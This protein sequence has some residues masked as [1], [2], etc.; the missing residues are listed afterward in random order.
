[1]SDNTIHLAIGVADAAPAG[2]EELKNQ[3]HQRGVNLLEKGERLFLYPIDDNLSDAF[4]E[5]GIDLNPEKVRL[6]LNWINPADQTVEDSDLTKQIKQVETFN[7]TFQLFDLPTVISYL[8]NNNEAVEDEETR[9]TGSS[10]RDITGSSNNEESQESEPDT[11]PESGEDDVIDQ[12]PDEFADDPPEPS[13]DKPDDAPEYSEEEPVEPPEQTESESEPEQGYDKSELSQMFD[14]NTPEDE[15]S[16]YV[17]D[18]DPWLQAAVKLF[19]SQTIGDDLPSFDSKTQDL[20]S[21]DIVDAN[22]HVDTARQKAIAS[23]YYGLKDSNDKEYAEAEKNEIAKAEKTH[24]QNIDKLKQNCETKIKKVE[25]EEKDK[26]NQRKHEAG[27]AAL[28]DFYSKYDSEHLDEVN[29]IITHR[30]Q[31]IKQELQ[32]NIGEENQSFDEYKDKVRQAVFNHVKEKY[33]V[34]SAVAGYRKV[35]DNETQRLMDR[36]KAAETENSRLKKQIEDYKRSKEISD[37]TYNSRLEAAVAQ[38]ID[39][40]THRYR[41]QVDDADDRRRAAED[42]NRVLRQKNEQYQEKLESVLDKFSNVADQYSKAQL[43]SQSVSPQAPQQYQPQHQPTQPASPQHRS[44]RFADAKGWKKYV[45][46]AGGILVAMS[47][48]STFTAFIIDSHQQPV[49][50][51][52]AQIQSQPH[53]SEN[54]TSGTAAKQS[55]SSPDT[56]TYT[57]KSGKKYAVIRDDDHSGHYIDDKG[58]THTVFINER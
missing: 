26:Y 53:V 57:T 15:E 50:Q 25:K 24:N 48:S 35:V 1:M 44:N 21:S 8:D 17:S 4:D 55:D 29:D 5:S 22:N 6:S 19:D 11:P 16:E 18:D 49:Q 38:G 34:A 46:I 3:A 39:E 52:S 56:F 23:I 32:D 10:I 40:K 14:D 54:S 43:Y 12:I 51:T 30:S 42:E 45:G 7:G 2:V 9:L 37:Q 27:E 33:N 31:P 41:I 28:K 20:V 47:L 58:V 13:E 36:V